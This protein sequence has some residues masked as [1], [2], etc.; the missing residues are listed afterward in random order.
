MEGLLWKKRA[1]L[2]ENGRYLKNSIID[3]Q[4]IE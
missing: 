4:K 3:Q 1:F 2:S